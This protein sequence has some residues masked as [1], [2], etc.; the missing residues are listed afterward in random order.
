MTWQGSV[1]RVE[2]RA[3]GPRGAA[4]QQPCL[5]CRCRA[6]PLLQGRSLAGTDVGGAPPPPPFSPILARTH[7]HPTHASLVAVKGRL[8]RL[9][10]GPI[11]LVPLRGQAC[12]NVCMC[13]FVG[14]CACKR[15]RSTNKAFY[16][17]PRRA[18][19]RAASASAP[20]LA[21]TSRSASCRAMAVGSSCWRPART[22]PA[23]RWPTPPPLPRHQVATVLSPHVLCPIALTH[24]CTVALLPLSA[25]CC[26]H[27][28]APL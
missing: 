19:R 4:V 9:R 26:G 3:A 15:V 28:N 7:A 21:R 13:V 11:L 2:P 17:R 14:G 5:D 18:A 16:Q 27:K 23:T 1:C 22:A 25:R 10:T 6:Q 12:M 20:R 24:A 8:L